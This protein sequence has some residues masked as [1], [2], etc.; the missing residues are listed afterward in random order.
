M[1]HAGLIFSGRLLLAASLCVAQQ[2]LAFAQ[3]TARVM[4]EIRDATGAPRAAVAAT[5]QGPALRTSLTDADGRFEF[6]TLPA[7]EY[8]LTTTL[9]GF[10]PATRSFRLADGETARFFLTLW[11]QLLEE[12][13][14]TAS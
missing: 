9:R 7:G 11:V 13:T 6:P 14:V 4:G 1:S 12:T 3:P 10:A 2:R 5:L 8:V